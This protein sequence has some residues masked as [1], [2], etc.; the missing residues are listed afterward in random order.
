MKTVLKDVEDEYNDIDLS[1][2]RNFIKDV[3]KEFINISS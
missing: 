3:V 1:T 2:K